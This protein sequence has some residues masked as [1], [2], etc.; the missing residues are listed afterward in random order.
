VTSDTA[1]VKS[2]QCK[3]SFPNSLFL[4]S[5]R[6]P[7]SFFSSFLLSTYL[8]P[9]VNNNIYA[10]FDKIR[11]FPHTHTRACGSWNWTI[12]FTLNQYSN[13]GLTSLYIEQTYW[14]KLESLK[15]ASEIMERRLL[16]CSQSIFFFDMQDSLY[17]HAIRYCLQCD[18]CLGYDRLDRNCC[19]PVSRIAGAWH[20]LNK[21]NNKLRGLSPRANYTFGLVVGVP[22]YK[23]R[24]PGSIP[25]TTSFSEK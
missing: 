15:F 4:P 20:Y 11:K 13:Y 22:G 19:N 18:W 17:L 12:K 16:P 21:T 9:C 7:F 10:S 3:L 23:S 5:F 14:K 2:Y 1:L 25:G 8:T 6:S 24:G